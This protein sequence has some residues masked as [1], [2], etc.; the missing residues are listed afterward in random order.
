M[1]RNFDLKKIFNINVQSLSRDNNKIN[2]LMT[3]QN[4]VISLICSSASKRR[5]VIS[6]GIIIKINF[7]FLIVHKNLKQT[8]L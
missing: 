4:Y 6:C 7:R 3:K 1:S 5:K 2:E 8:V